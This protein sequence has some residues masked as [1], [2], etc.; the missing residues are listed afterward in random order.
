VPAPPHDHEDFATEQLDVE[1]GIAPEALRAR[2]EALQALRVKGFVETSAGLRLVQAVGPRVELEPTTS[3][4]PAG[5]LGRLVIIR[6]QRK[7]SARRA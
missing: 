2:V 1:P 3:A 7:R 6:R 4:P 5:A